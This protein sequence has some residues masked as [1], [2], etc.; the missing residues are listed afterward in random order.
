[1]SN[2]I[3]KTPIAIN[4]PIK[5]YAPG[6]PERTELQKMLKD[7]VAEHRDIPMYGAMD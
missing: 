6:S 4:E 2:G 5:S 1:M 3:F 7:S